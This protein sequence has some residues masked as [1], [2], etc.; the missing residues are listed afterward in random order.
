MKWLLFS[1]VVAAVGSVT[2]FM[3]GLYWLAPFS[4]GASVTFLYAAM[5]VRQ[6]D[7][8]REAG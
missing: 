3:N 5:K 6:G 2:Q 7:N 8:D 4:A 1:A